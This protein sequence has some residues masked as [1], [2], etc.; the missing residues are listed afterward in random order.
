MNR[1]SIRYW[2]SWGNIEDIRRC[3]LDN[4]K[5]TASGCWEWTRQRN[6]QGYGVQ[7]V[8][9]KDCVVHRVSKAIFDGFDRG[10]ELDVCHH[11][12]NPPCFN[13]EHLFV[14][15]HTDNM[16]DMFR[17]GR[18]TRMRGV[19]QHLAK[20]N[21]GSVRKMRK[22]RAR[23]MSYQELGRKYGV[24]KCTAMIACKGRT[25]KHVT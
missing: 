19:R 1:P 12:D 8:D 9:G 6:I 16:R 4:K 11:C 22:D 25:W 20:L 18:R 3:L 24:A 15:T 7:R 21:D 13:P 2:L 10:S 14:G 17:K 5:T 23:G